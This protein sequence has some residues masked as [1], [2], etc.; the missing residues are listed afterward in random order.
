MLPFCMDFTRNP[1]EKFISLWCVRK[2][3]LTICTY[4]QCDPAKLRSSDAISILYV[5]LMRIV[6]VNQVNPWDR[7]QNFQ[8]W[9]TYV[10]WKH[11][12]GWGLLSGGF[13]PCSTHFLDHRTTNEQS[14]VRHADHAILCSPVGPI[15]GH[16]MD[17]VLWT[18]PS[19]EH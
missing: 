15:Y 8:K 1:P 13:T 4:E 11:L 6:T 10:C 9:C 16:Y 3:G 12:F 5:F 2:H 17:G 7:C 19:K 18:S 14:N